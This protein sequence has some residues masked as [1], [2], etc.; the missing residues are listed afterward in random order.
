MSTTTLN[1]L[2]LVSYKG[3]SYNQTDRLQPLCPDF[4]GLHIATMYYGKCPYKNSG[5][6]LQRVDTMSTAVTRLSFAIHY[7]DLC[8]RE[9][10]EGTYFCIWIETFTYIS[11]V[12]LTYQG[13]RYR[14]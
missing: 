6:Q 3:R 13:P 4:D 8:N 14:V 12:A 10:L 2:M 1:P 9:A 7:M 11:F 5:R